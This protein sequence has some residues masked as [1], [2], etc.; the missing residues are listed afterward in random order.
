[1][2][3]SFH[4]YYWTSKVFVQWCTFKDVAIAMYLLQ[5][6][7]APGISIIMKKH[8]RNY[9]LQGSTVFTGLYSDCD[10]QVIT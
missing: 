1:M 10:I 5:Q 7:L 2:F 9:E 6:S 4:S 8:T 3:H